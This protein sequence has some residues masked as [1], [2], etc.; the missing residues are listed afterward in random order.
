MPR[1]SLA[2]PIDLFPM[3]DFGRG[4]VM[5]T[6]PPVNCI[7]MAFATLLPP[8]TCRRTGLTEPERSA[9]APVKCCRTGLGDR[10]VICVGRAKD[11]VPKIPVCAGL[12]GCPASDRPPT[13]GPSKPMHSRHQTPP[14]PSVRAW[15][16][17]FLPQPGPVLSLLVRVFRQSFPPHTRHA[18]CQRMPFGPWTTPFSI[19]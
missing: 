18:L 6:P 4:R 8:V 19:W 3:T 2:L 1:L 12:R 16:S 11:W 5:G 13:V 9:E 15:E 17:S 10:P 14:S 7:C